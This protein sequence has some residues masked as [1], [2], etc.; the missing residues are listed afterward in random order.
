MIQLYLSLVLLWL[1]IPLGSLSILMI[2]HL[3][4]G[5]WG[6]FLRPTLE[7]MIK[8]LPLTA[9]AFVPL[10]FFLKHLFPWT[11]GVQDSGLRGAWLTTPF[12]IIRNLLY[13]SFWIGLS[14]RLVRK[15]GPYK[16]LSSVG[17]ILHSLVVSFFAID[18]MMSLEPDWSSTVFGLILMTSQ[19]LSALAVC[20]LY[21]CFSK[22]KPLPAI[23]RDWGN[24]LLTFTLFWAYLGYS[25]YIVIWQGGL[26]DEVVWY[27]H[28]TT[29][30]WKS[31]AI[32]IVVFG[33]VLPFFL[34]LFRRIKDTPW[35][36]GCV[37]VAIVLTRILDQLW[38]ILPS[39]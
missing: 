5:D 18:W 4:G 28:R 14:W 11:S 20:V 6:K 7:A 3:T 39:F 12:F 22:S 16:R 36:L 13:F 37:A 33:L 17:L 30:F 35:A 26:P 32:T 21:H 19:A 29:R 31:T 8:T 34:L 38:L 10:L 25:Q 23:S 2:F 9:L 24:L 1:Q 27:A 15:T